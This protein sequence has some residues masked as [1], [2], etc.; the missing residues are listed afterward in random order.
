MREEKKKQRAG[1]AVSALQFYLFAV[2]LKCWI[3]LVHQMLGCDG[4]GGAVVN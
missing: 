2:V 3:V 1:W 4:A